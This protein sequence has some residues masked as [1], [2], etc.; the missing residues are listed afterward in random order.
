MSYT[1]SSLW[2]DLRLRH[3][4]HGRSPTRRTPVTLTPLWGDGRKWEKFWRVSLANHP[5]VVKR[6]RQSLKKRS[7]NQE[8]KS[9]IK[10]LIKKARHAVA[11]QNSE[12]A[13][14]EVRAVDRELSK[15]VSK[16]IIK[17]NTASRWLSRLARSASRLSSA[18]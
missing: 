8:T 15:A 13:S 14:T 9:K 4:S 10:T 2:P 11:S 17:R 5:S 16:G 6:H 18:Q 3:P 1:R 12:S 7:R